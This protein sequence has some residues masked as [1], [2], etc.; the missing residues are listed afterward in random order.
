MVQVVHQRTPRNRAALPATSG[1]T[2]HLSTIKLLLS[3]YRNRGK[4]K[5]YVAFCLWTF[6]SWVLTTFFQVHVGA[7]ARHVGG[8][9]ATI[10]FE[11]LRLFQTK[12]TL[13]VN[14]V[15]LLTGSWTTEL[16]T[17]PWMSHTSRSRCNIPLYSSSWLLS[18][19]SS[20]CSRCSFGLDALVLD[21]EMTSRTSMVKHIE[22][23]VSG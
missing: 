5:A 9:A 2:F 14:P 12:S 23:S 10:R 8:E 15:R 21:T 16:S 11:F 13:I 19:V 22:S 17:P 18:S 1:H 7:I 3:L 4:K 6:C 20:P